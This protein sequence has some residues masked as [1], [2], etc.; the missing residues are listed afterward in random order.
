MDMDIQVLNGRDNSLEQGEQRQDRPRQ[1]AVI[2]QY[3]KLMV[4]GLWR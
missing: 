1:A 2:A 3:F 4:L